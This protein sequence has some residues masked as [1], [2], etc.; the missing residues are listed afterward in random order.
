ME[1][2]QPLISVIIPCYNASDFLR[3]ALDSIVNQTYK[4]LEIICID[5]CSTDGTAQILTEYSLKD[6]RIVIIKNEENLKLIRTLN[7][8]ITL[9]KGDYIARMDADDMCSL[10][11]FEIQLNYLIDNPNC[12]IIST[13]ARE[14]SEDGKFLRLNMP[15]QLTAYGSTFASFFFTPIGHALL[16]CKSEVLKENHFRFEDYCFHTEDYEL[17]TRLV[18]KNK[19]LDNIYQALYDYRINSKSVSRQFSTLQ[20]ENFL[21][22]AKLHYELY[23]NQ[24]VDIDE[25]RVFINRMEK[26]VNL[27]NFR[28]GLRRIYVLRDFFSRKKLTEI[29]KSEIYVIFYTH[30]FDVCFQA[31]KKGNPYTKGVSLF[32][33]LSISPY[34][35][36]NTEIR[37]YILHKF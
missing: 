12:D 8:G 22:C 20:D 29:E 2:K 35:L 11:R 36:S 7:K 21:K 33:L 10:N 28:K 23:F 32:K 15:R 16:L 31:L 18:R 34:L 4:N 6:N 37:K 30:F 9:A 13:G 27:I 1:N 19:N 26:G 3:E 25:F 14:I 5:D 17:W 24:S